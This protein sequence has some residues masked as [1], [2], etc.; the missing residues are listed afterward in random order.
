M[1]CLPGRVGQ[2]LTVA[3]VMWTT[4]ITNGPGRLSLAR[5]C[6]SGQ[7]HRQVHALD[8]TISYDTTLGYL[9]MTAPHG[10]G[11]LDMTPLST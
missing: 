8:Q 6:L 10:L 3:F 9:D 2:L 11:H 1:T 5:A 7:I 4:P